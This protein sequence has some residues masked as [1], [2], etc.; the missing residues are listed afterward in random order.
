MT[1]LTIVGLVFLATLALALHRARS[2]LDVARR[3]EAA[4]DAALDR[5]RDFAKAGCDLLWELDEQLQYSFVKNLTGVASPLDSSTVLGATPWELAEADPE[6]D[7]LWHA[8]REILQTHR[9]FRDF[10]HSFRLSGG[11]IS[12]WTLSGTPIL[13]A[14]GVF[15]GYRGAAVEVTAEVDARQRADRA[16]ARLAE[17]IENFS[18]GFVLYDPEGCFVACN[19]K[20]REL[21]NAIEDLLMPGT[22]METMVKA[23][24]DRGVIRRSTD[25][26]AAKA[27]GLSR[28]EVS[29]FSER[30]A[31]VQM[32]DGRW[33]LVQ[34]RRLPDGGIVGIR[35]DITEIKKRERAL[36]EQESR[37]RAIIEAINDAVFVK[38]LFGRYVMCNTA[39]T[40]LINKSIEESL[41][42][43]DAELFPADMA[44]KIMISD[45][46]V[47][48]SGRTRVDETETVIDGE[49]CYLTTTKTVYRDAQGAALGIVGVTSDITHRKRAE[50]E[51]RNAKEQ[52]ELANRAK[53]AFLANMS[54]ELR[55][56]LNAIIGFAEIIQMEMLGPVGTERYL[57]YAADIGTSGHHLLNLIN[58]LLDL[59]K[60]EAGKLELHEAWVEVPATVDTCL[61]LV[62]E[63][64]LNHGV[65]LTTE[66][67]GALPAI[68]ADERALKQ[69]LLNLLTNA[70]KFTP[71]GGRVTVRAVIDEDDRL[72]LSVADTGIGIAEKDMPRVLEAFGQVDSAMNR[73]HAGTGLGLPLTRRLIEL[74]GGEFAIESAVGKGTTVSAHFPALR[75]YTEAEPIKRAVLATA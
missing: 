13:D 17:A 65:E 24:I 7:E 19:S 29:R 22:P 57:E 15:R 32:A 70:V 63:R 48:H 30:A 14:S 75:T 67:I 71:H 66:L 44:R 1:I 54:H 27:L 4:A 5:Y 10:R 56:P 53:S 6:Q 64:A 35:T 61:R 69:I 38:D 21:F 47:I 8:Y 16:E 58:D 26:D 9:A 50:A 37:L 34:N 31:E 72:R 2:R 43:T 51:L 12:Y 60:I 39:G 3:A 23:V 59:S 18:E 42:K 52:A 11:R 41:G 46:D 25:S 62:K 36:A 74:H 20:Y 55:T 73:K 28:F 40:R 49:T 33:L 68:W 45:H